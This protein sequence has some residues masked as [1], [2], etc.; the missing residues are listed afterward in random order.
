[1][2]VIYRYLDCGD[3]HFDFARV[4]CEAVLDYRKPL[5]RQQTSESGSP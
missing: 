4:R 2:E 1:M 3:L 5:V